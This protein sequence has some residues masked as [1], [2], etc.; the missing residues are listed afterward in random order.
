[1]SFELTPAQ[2]AAADQVQSGICD[3]I[4]HLDKLAPLA[5]EACGDRQKSVLA[6]ASAM[7]SALAQHMVPELVI[8]ELTLR[9]HEAAQ[10]D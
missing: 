5:L 6:I 3:I 9:R 2:L 4:D 8:A 1:M 10:N 7:K